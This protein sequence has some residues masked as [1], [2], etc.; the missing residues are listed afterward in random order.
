MSPEQAGGA[1]GDYRSDQFSLGL[2]LYELATG[3]RAFERTR[4]TKFGTGP[5]LRRH[6]L[7]ANPADSERTCQL[8]AAT[9]AWF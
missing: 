3:K 9:H 4:Q 8:V 6:A 2:I 5:R 1:F 7:A